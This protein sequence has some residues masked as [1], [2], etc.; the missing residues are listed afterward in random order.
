MKARENPMDTTKTQRNVF[1]TGGW[2]SVFRVL[3]LLLIEKRPVQPIY[4]LDPQRWSVTQE[5]K[6]MAK[7]KQA[8]ISRFP[9]SEALLLPTIMYDRTDIEFD[10]EIKE[11]EQAVF[12]KVHIGGQ[13]EWLAG[14]AKQFGIEDP[15]LCVENTDSGCNPSVRDHL[16]DGADGIK[17]VDPAK[18]GEPEHTLYGAFS[19]P[20]FTLTKTDMRDIAARH[21]F[22]DILELSWF[23]HRPTLWDQ[24]CGTCNPCKDAMTKGM[25][26]RM[27][28][29]GRFR[30]H[31]KQMFDPRTH[32]KKHPYLYDKAKQLRERLRQ[33]GR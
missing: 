5:L 8:V 20:T 6:A 2:D 17:R 23:C 24:P 10:P 16:V 7:I 31:L 33:R 21:D 9:E 14:A 15:E 25:E 19:F 28:V 12:R 18:A 32:L 27:P 13:Y 29:Y 1:V 26:H 3:Q 11:A 4:I 30:Y 22:L